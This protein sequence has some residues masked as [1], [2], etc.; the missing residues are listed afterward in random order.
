[1]ANIPTREPGFF[2]AGDTVKWTRSIPDYPASQGWTLKYFL[3]GPS[4]LDVSAS[5]Y[6]A[7]EDYIV[8]IAASASATLTAGDYAWTAKVASADGSETY[9]VNFGTVTVKPDLSKQVAGYDGRSQTKRQLDNINDTIEKLTKKG[10]KSVQLNGKVYTLKDLNAEL[11]P[12]Q[13]ALQAQYEREQ[14]RDRI[15]QGQA[16]GRRILTGFRR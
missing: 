9:T 4:A 16:G 5:Q 6:N 7:T 12:A 10:Y 11:L 14:A 3:R 2:T 15:D 8:T 1:M 13:A